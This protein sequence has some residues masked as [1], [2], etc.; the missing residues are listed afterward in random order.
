VSPDWPEFLKPACFVLGYA[1]ME[2]SRKAYHTERSE[3]SEANY[4]NSIRKLPKYLSGEKD[5][6]ETRVKAL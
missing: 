6:I 4:L 2:D 3:Y 5:Y 1:R